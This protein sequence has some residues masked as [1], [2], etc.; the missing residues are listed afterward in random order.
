MTSF[1]HPNLQEVPSNRLAQWQRMD[2]LRKHFWTRWSKEYISLL[3]Q[4][5]KWK[6]LQ[7][8]IE[9]GQLVL[10]K[11]DNLPPL[12]WVTGRIVQLFPGQDK[13]TR[14]VLINTS[15]GLINRYRECVYCQLTLVLKTRYGSI[16]G[17]LEL[18]LLLF[19]V[20]ESTSFKWGNIS[21]TATAPGFPHLS[22]IWD[23]PAT[24]AECA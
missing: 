3:Q 10:I 4:R 19:F 24:L 5:S 9:L 2:Q 1:P 12:R 6:S 16:A 18:S 15:S 22:S 21:E 17:V 23:Q 8:N 20:F 7:A 14:V 11:K 13:I